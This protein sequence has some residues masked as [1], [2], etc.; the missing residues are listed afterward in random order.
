MPTLREMHRA[1]AKHPALQ[2]R[3]FLLL[4]E[5]VHAELLGTTAFLGSK[6]YA[7]KQPVREDDYSTL[8]QIGIAQLVRSGLKPLEA[9][10][11]GFARGHGK[12][13]SAP[14]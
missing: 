7:T 1:L 14:R 13:T 6:N 11:R 9:Q 5:L 4:D 3:V 10:G 2:A 12:C 8:C